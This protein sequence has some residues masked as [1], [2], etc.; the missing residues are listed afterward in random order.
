MF[1]VYYREL[2]DD[3]LGVYNK[4]GLQQY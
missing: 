2:D 4:Y 3:P 1:Y